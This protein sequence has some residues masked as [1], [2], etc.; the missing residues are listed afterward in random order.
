VAQIYLKRLNRWRRNSSPYI[1]GDAFADLA[2]FV[3]NPPRWRNL[4]R[5]TFISDA[6]IIFCKSHDLQ[7][8]FDL[9]AKD[10]GAKVI[11][12]GNSDFEFHAAPT[13]IPRSVRALFLQNSY[14][15]D[16]KFVFTL[17]IGIENFRLG[18]NGNPKYIKK[19]TNSRLNFRRVLIG[20]LSATHPI[21]SH[22]LHKFPK[23]HEIW[24]LVVN[25]LTPKE[26]NEVANSYSLIAAI[27]GNGIDT[28]RLWESLYR[29]LTPIVMRDE[30]WKSLEEVYPQV[31]TIC[32]WSESELHR[33]AREFRADDWEPQEIQALWM[34]YWEKKIQ[35]FLVD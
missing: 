23:Q 4:K 20:P 28:H 1:S 8:L 25:R 12:T 2:N 26:Y 3:Y 13:N 31:I 7:N 19:L 32:E 35:S 21:R 15:S 18:V 17:P 9:H 30:W 6:E 34:P 16:D 33:A 5:N 27:R 22:V 10:I 29:G 24:D 14:I 11:I